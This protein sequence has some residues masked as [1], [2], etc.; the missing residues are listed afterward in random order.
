MNW[1]ITGATGFIGNKL[2]AKLGSTA[3]PVSLRDAEWPKA[4]A[5]RKLSG[6]VH[7]AGFAHSRGSEEEIRRV[8]VGKT[9]ALAGEAI[10]QGVKRFI[11]FRSEYFREEFRQ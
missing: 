11:F 5:S 9:Q 7:L 6:V 2:L 8:N 3:Q 4:F 10:N 1:L